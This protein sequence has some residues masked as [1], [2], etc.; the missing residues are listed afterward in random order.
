MTSST[1]TPPRTPI[2]SRRGAGCPRRVDR[3][4]LTACPARTPHLTSLPRP[5]AGMDHMATPSGRG[6]PW[7]SVTTGLDPRHMGIAGGSGKG[8][9]MRMSKAGLCTTTATPAFSTVAHCPP[10]WRAQAL[11]NGDDAIC[12]HRPRRSRRSD[13]FQEACQDV[14]VKTSRAPRRVGCTTSP[15]AGRPR[16]R[17]ATASHIC[18]LAENNKGLSNMWALSSRWPTKS[19]TSTRN[20]TSTR[21]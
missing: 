7:S 18:L 5:V 8:R 21:H 3:L 19:S 1:R 20:P 13:P 4:H 10:R 11:A 6:A 15:P 17:A 16:P 12:N 2:R 14:G 9:G